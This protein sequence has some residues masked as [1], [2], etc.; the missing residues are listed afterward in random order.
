MNLRMILLCAL[1]EMTARA[2]APPVS[3]SFPTEPAASNPPP[4]AT[5]HDPIEQLLISSYGGSVGRDASH[6]KV[7]CYYK[8]ERTEPGK[9]TVSLWDT[10]V[11][12]ASVNTKT[13]V[14]PEKNHW[15]LDNGSLLLTYV[16]ENEDEG[17]TF[18]LWFAP[19]TH[20]I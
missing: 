12:D 17:L 20:W 13:A 8:V 16:F 4:K 18:K 10:F 7:V 1:L 11:W 6:D 19:K 15:S 9:Y 14:Y 3:V 5:A 2:S